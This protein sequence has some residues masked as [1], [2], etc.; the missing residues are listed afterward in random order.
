MAF[1]S[2]DL[3]VQ[4]AKGSPVWKGLVVFGSL[5]VLKEQVAARNAHLLERRTNATTHFLDAV[6]IV[7]LALASVMRY[8]P[9][10]DKKVID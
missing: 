1:A 7:V 5:T 4:L 8:E 9:S 10:E 6:G 2:Q 3:A